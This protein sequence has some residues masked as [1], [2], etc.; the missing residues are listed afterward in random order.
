MI[1]KANLPKRWSEDLAYLFGLL[2]GDGSLPSAY[3]KRPNGK[4]Q[5]RHLIYFIS[6]SKNFCDYVY[7]PSF[8]KLFGITPKIEFV[9]NK[10]NPL[11][12][13]RIESKIIYEFLIKKGYI[14]GRKAKIAKIPKMPK[15]YYYH[16]LAG[17]LDTDGGK[18]GS[19]FGL[20]TASEN[21][22]KFCIQAFKNLNLPYHSCPWRYKDHIYH[23]IY[24]GK[25]NM[26]KILK[27]VPL[28]NN[29][30][31]AFLQS[32]TPR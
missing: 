7:I 11:Y 5:K 6:N 24:I 29:E 15:K 4:Y 18:K 2:I 1:Y 14:P 30:K 21:L 20:S 3:S 10:I 25:K 8:K 23:Q 27:S 22:A 19:G 9:K 16:I 13:C 32:Y 17:L 12:N 31:I 26:A 28:K